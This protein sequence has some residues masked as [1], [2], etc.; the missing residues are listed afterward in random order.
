MNDT[1]TTPDRAP[2]KR[3]HASWLKEHRTPLVSSALIAAVVITCSCVGAAL[4]SNREADA[5]AAVQ[6]TDSVHE[7]AVAEISEL[8]AERA[9]DAGHSELAQHLTR[10]SAVLAVDP[11]IIDESS[12]TKLADLIQEA[13]AAPAAFIPDAGD[14]KRAVGATASMAE[15]VAADEALGKRIARVV[16]A[17]ALCTSKLTAI[18]EI[19]ADVLDAFRVAVETTAAAQTDAVLAGLPSAEKS[20]RDQAAVTLAALIAD[21]DARKPS[22]AMATFSAAGAHA[23]SLQAV[24]ASHAAVEEQKALAAS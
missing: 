5:A 22:T 16:K 19:D 4:I 8:A 3:A 15:Y 10:L 6:F 1:T 24:H 14:V 12:R 13:P 17:T 18:Q 11:A 7:L 2:A 20:A 21:I 23:A 9:L